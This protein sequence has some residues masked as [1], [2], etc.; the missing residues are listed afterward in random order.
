MA[1]IVPSARPAFEGVDVD[2]RAQWR[3]D[4]V[5]GVEAEQGFVGEAEVVWCHLRGDWQAVCLRLP[6]ELDAPR[7]GQM[8]EVHPDAGE[9]DELDVAVEHQL[10]GDRR[11]ARHAHRA[12]AFAF[13]HH[14]TFGEPGDLTVLG[15]GDTEAAGVLQR[16]PHQQRI[17]HAGAVVGEE[18]HTG[19]GELGIRRQRLTEAA[20]RDATG[21]Q[22]LAQGGQIALPPHEVDDRP[23]VVRWRRVGH[24]HDRREPAQSRGATAGLDRLRLFLAGLA[25]VGVEIDEAGSHDA[26]GG[27]EHGRGLTDVERLADLGDISVCRC[28]RPPAVRRSGR[29]LGRRR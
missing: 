5:R 27:I 28:G 1:S 9:S 24:R 29:A 6:D 21:R 7:R 3:V 23:C 11:P 8:Q 15:E 22:H 17:L 12:A 10:F 18:V 4:L 20:N 2:L 26:A 13:V 14:G 25:E 16:P 19:S